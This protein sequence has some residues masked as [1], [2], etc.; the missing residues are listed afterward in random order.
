MLSKNG[1]GLEKGKSLITKHC[2]VTERFVL[3]S[4]HKL[5]QK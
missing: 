4:C 1:Q 5:F 2:R 3:I